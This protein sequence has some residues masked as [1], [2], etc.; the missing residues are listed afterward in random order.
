LPISVDPAVEVSRLPAI[1]HD[2]FDRMLIAQARLER[3]EIVTRDDNIIAYG[4]PY[5][6]A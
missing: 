6:R 2:P 1:H 5:I 4:V 3:L